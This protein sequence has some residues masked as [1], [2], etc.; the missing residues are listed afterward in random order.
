ML[1]LNKSR[2]AKN[3]VTQY[4]H[5][6]ITIR[7]SRSSAEHIFLLPLFRDLLTIKPKLFLEHFV[8]FNDQELDNCMKNRKFD[9]IFESVVKNTSIRFLHRINS[10]PKQSNLLLLNGIPKL[11]PKLCSCS[12]KNVLF[13]LH[14]YKHRQLATLT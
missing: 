5:N 4:A 14:F 9:F 12:Q 10:N 8:N 13:Q 11:V 3:R 7:S 2:R 6:K 1:S